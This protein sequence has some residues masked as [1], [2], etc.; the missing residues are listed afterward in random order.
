MSRTRDT[1][2]A[3]SAADG[4]WKVLGRF[5]RQAILV[6]LAIVAIGLVT[7]LRS[8]QAQTRGAVQASSGHLDR[9]E[10][11]FYVLSGLERGQTL[12]VY[13]SGTSGNLN[14]NPDLQHF[15]SRFCT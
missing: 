15:L 12:Y 8:A 10:G 13:A 9:G 1:E 14:R 6:L 3:Y 4:A 11:A 7:G 2:V 5:A